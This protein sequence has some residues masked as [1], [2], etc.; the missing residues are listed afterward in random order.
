MVALRHRAR[1][2]RAG[3]LEVWTEAKTQFEAE[4]LGAPTLA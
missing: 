3:A 2:L 4:L 1:E